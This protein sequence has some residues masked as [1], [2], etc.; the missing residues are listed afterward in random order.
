MKLRPMGKAI[1][2][3]RAGF[4]AAF[5]HPQARVLLAARSA[6]QGIIVLSCAAALILAGQPLPL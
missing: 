6:V 2:F 5:Q 4:D 3:T 1:T